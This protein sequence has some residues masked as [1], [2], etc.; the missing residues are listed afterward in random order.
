MTELNHMTGC[1]SI[2]RIVIFIRHC[3]NSRRWIASVL[4]VKSKGHNGVSVVKNQANV[5]W[6]DSGRQR[7]SFEMPR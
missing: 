6:Q 7:P 5:I 1:C 4:Q 2:V 3:H